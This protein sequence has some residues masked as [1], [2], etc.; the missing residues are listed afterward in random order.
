M[1]EGVY[2]GRGK[3]FPPISFPVD[4]CFFEEPGFI[5]MLCKGTIA[6]CSQA[7]AEKEG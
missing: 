2:F 7:V 4:V 6:Y 3:S 1:N 5:Q